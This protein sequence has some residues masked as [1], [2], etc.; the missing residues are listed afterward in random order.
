MESY[1]W[2][3]TMALSFDH[4]LCPLFVPVS[5]I[6]WGDKLSLVTLKQTKQYEAKSWFKTYVGKFKDFEV[7]YRL[8]VLLYNNHYYLMNAFYVPEAFLNT[9]PTQ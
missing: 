2:L 3:F 5:Y 1:N 9:E 7:L 8:C 6:S 4:F